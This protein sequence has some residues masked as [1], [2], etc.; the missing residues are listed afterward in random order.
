VAQL[1]LD[2]PAQYI[3]GIGPKRAERLAAL[4]IH[5]VSD[6]ILHLPFRYERE[7]P[8]CSVRELELGE[9]CTVIGK[10]ASVRSH[11]GFRRPS[12]VVRIVDATGQCWAR[13]FN[14]SWVQSNVTP[15]DTIRVSGIV[16][17]YKGRPQFV[18]PSLRVLAEDEDD[19]VA[20]Q[21]RLLPVY[22]TVAGITSQQI[23]RAVDRVLPAVIDQVDEW[24]DEGFRRKRDLPLRRV[25]I[26]RLHK[27]VGID[28]A[29]L[30]R[31]RLAYDELFLMQ[32]AILLKR[33]HAKSSLQGPSIVNTDLIDGRI[34]RRFPFKLTAA[35]EKAIHD[36]VSDLAKPVPMNRLLQGDV[37]SGKTV[38]ALYAA[39]LTVA[40]RHQVAIMAPTEILAEQHH[41]S[42]QTYLAGSRV[43]TSLLVGGLPRSQRDDCVD[44]IA[45]GE[46]DIVVGTQAL[47]ERDVMFHRLGL[48][49]VD[50]QHKFGVV[51]RATIRS[52]AGSRYPHYL[53]M[54]ATPI[55]RT[56]AM[57]LFGDLDVSVIDALPPGRRPVR[58]RYVSPN[59][60][61]TAWDFVRE[62]ISAGEQ[63]YIV[64]PLVEESDDSSLSAV[65]VE[66]ERLRHSILPGCRIELL[67]GRMKSHEK[68]RIMRRFVSGQIDVLAATTVVEVG[69]DVP[70]ATIM[71]I[72]N[73]ERFGLSQLHQLRGRIGRGS[74]PSH[75]LLMAA[76]PGQTAR[77][78]REVLVRTTD[79]FQIAE[80]D[81]LLRGPGDLLGGERQ[82]GFDLRIADLV[83]DVQLLAMARS[84]AAD[85]LAEDPHLTDRKHAP[86]R[87]ALLRAMPGRLELIDV[88]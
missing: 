68:E 86:I 78:R 67:H 64:C 63:A 47:L 10:A 36:I 12:V 38:V 72:Q 62:R 50:E 39:L 69:I 2:S 76:D 18:N 31:R 17:E 7:P 58:T 49:I 44:R 33:R 32:L 56:L 34:R 45:R 20:G 65:T 23:A 79:G 84:D 88:G 5:T 21:P 37:G 3:P 1:T 87:N 75:C 51:Q 4:G 40:H 6:L 71:V 61:Q 14:A 57:T 46:V 16:G 19:R 43:R 74:R 81:L 28:D 30:A 70:N 35:Q 66:V 13:W 26:E 82:H 25:A 24:F 52:K 83:A 22:S 73:A 8:A 85:L 9:A 27:P 54:T 42:I 48:V 59:D 80:E 11:G 60:T 53:V 41:R 15:G 77:T 55:P 29:P